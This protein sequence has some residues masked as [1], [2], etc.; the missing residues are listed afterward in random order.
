MF[1]VGSGLGVVDTIHNSLLSFSPALYN[2]GGGP[3]NHI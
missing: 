2:G 1:I 3:L